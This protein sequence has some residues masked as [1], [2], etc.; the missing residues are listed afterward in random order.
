MIE[1]G[2]QTATRITAPTCP[3]GVKPT[4]CTI[5]LTQVTG[6]EVVRDGISYPT[7]VTK[8]GRIVA[9][10]VG[11][12]ALSSDPKT[13]QKY[14]NNLDSTYGGQPLA[15]ITVLSPSGPNRWTV[16]AESGAFRLEPYLGQVAQFPLDESLPAEPGDVVALTVPTWAPVLSI[17]VKPAAK[18]E[19][20]QSRLFNCPNPP[21][22]SQAQ[23]KVGTTTT[24]GC[25]YK[26]TRI[27]YSAT[28][29]TH[30]NPTP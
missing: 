28:E 13:R 3:P 26:G 21:N 10:T 12:S 24:Y 23:V 1:L 29:I 19:Y 4:N 15:A 17:M 9:F 7:R 18:F 2:G 11:L 14:I 22:S 6:L 20:R 27:E 16:A 8:R 30:P 5:V 25:D